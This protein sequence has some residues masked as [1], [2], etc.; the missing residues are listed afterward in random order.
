MAKNSLAGKTTSSINSNK[1]TAN[2][3]SMH[4]IMKGKTFLKI[5]TN[6]RQ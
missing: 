4:Q 6:N 5:K 2:K 3:R 1:K